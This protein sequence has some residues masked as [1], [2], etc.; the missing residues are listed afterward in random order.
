M[1]T[2]LKSMED[3]LLETTDEMEPLGLIK[4]ARIVASFLYAPLKL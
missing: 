4:S 3:A 2:V 1:T